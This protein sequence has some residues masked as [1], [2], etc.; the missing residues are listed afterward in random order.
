MRKTLAALALAT[1]IALPALAQTTGGRWIE[2][3]VRG[4]QFDTPAHE[5]LNQYD[6]F[7]IRTL[8]WRWTTHSGTRP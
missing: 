3:G 8:H 6:V 4:G 1:I 5:T 2:V 7:A